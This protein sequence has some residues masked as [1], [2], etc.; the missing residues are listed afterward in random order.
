MANTCKTCQRPDVAAIDKLLA[1][2]TPL[3]NIVAQYAGATV[4]GLKRHKDNCLEELLEEVRDQRRAGL[5]ADVDDVRTQIQALEQRFIDNGPVMVA[6]VSRRLEAVDKEAKLTGAYIKDAEN[7]A[8]LKSVAKI[9]ADFRERI[10]RDADIYAETDGKYGYAMP[11]DSF[12]ESEIEKLCRRF[13]VKPEQL[14]TLELG[15]I[16]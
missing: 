7:P 16:G 13:K 15:G 8:D 1:G 2:N 6:L 14:A 10:K 3:R 9:V 5:L 12:V 11:D 4:A